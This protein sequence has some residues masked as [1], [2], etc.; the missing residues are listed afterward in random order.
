MDIK[1]INV[2][3][4]GNCYYRCIWN[5]ARSVPEIADALMIH[6][7]TDEKE[8]ADE[9]RYY[10]A[11]SIRMETYAQKIIDNLVELYKEVP[12]LVEQYPILGH[13]K[14][15]NAGKKDIYNSIS[16][17]IENT[18]VMASSLEHEIIAERL[19]DSVLDPPLDCRMIIL[20]QNPGEDKTDLA[21][22]W[23][24]QLHVAL[25]KIENEYVIVL[26][27]EDNIHYKYTKLLGKIMVKTNEF[28]TYIN[29][30]ME[31]STEEEESSDDD[32]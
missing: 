16:K 3:G 12:D 19:V 18:S 4:D 14:D 22:K 6:D 17:V 2:R 27:N 25:D 5:I 32:Y 7:L 21:D 24:R 9:V 29:E 15:V 28:K 10:V 30:K 1:V 31:C 11:L 26:I 13:I 8:G 20:S 23:L